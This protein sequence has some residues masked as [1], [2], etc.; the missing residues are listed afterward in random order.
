MSTNRGMNWQPGAST[1]KRR[2]KI[3]VKIGQKSTPSYPRCQQREAREGC[4]VFQVRTAQRKTA[5][6][7]IDW[8]LF[9]IQTEWR[10][11]AIRIQVCRNIENECNSSKRPVLMQNMYPL[12]NQALHPRIK[13]ISR[14]IQCSTPKATPTHRERDCLIRSVNNAPDSKCEPRRVQPRR[15]NF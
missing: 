15:T 10:R 1:P 7:S 6:R 2:P 3:A 5:S 9:S 12:S 13:V 11:N 4:P 8:A 14:K